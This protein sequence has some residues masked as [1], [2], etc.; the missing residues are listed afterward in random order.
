MSGYV[1]TEQ[2]EQ[3]LND[4][5][6]YISHQNID[7][8]VADP[9]NGFNQG[10]AVFRATTDRDKVRKFIFE[11]PVVR[12]AH[13]RSRTLRINSLNCRAKSGIS[14]VRPPP[15]VVEAWS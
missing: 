9:F 6:D 12:L 14:G 7:D 8:A 3:D 11:S 1:L 10:S 2:A 15:R 13:T 5:W 4:I